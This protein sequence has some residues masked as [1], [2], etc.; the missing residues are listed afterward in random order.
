MTKII[1]GI[2]LAALA[3]LSCAD[4]PGN[5]AVQ[6]SEEKETVPPRDWPFESIEEI[7]KASLTL[8]AWKINVLPTVRTQLT[9]KDDGRTAGQLMVSCLSPSK[10]RDVTIYYE[11]PFENKDRVYLTFGYSVRGNPYL[12]HVKAEAS[13]PSRGVRTL[14]L[15]ELDEIILYGILGS[16][17]GPAILNVSRSEVGYEREYRVDLT[18]FLQA[19]QYLDEHPMCW[20]SRPTL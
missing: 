17:D 3:G 19:A 9:E 11:H 5:K 20:R 2:L 7:G 12:W 13:A 8:G 1:A 15:T 16:A 6:P 10:H 18:G 14:D 4:A